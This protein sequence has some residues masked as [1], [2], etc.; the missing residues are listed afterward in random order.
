MKYL[1]LAFAVTLFISCAQ[2][3]KDNTQTKDQEEMMP[4]EPDGGIGDGAPSL[5]AAI[6]QTVESAHNK[7]AFLNNKMVSF[8]IVLSFGGSERLN[9]SIDM[10]TDTSQLRINKK[11]GS[12]QI[13]DGEH[14]YVTPADANTQGARFSAFTWTYF[15][16]LPYKLT[17]N[18]VNIEIKNK[19]PMS[20]DTMMNAFK[21]TFDAGIGDAPDDYYVVYTND[22]NQIKAAGYIVTYGGTSTQKAEENAHAIV[23]DD[24]QIVNG[25]PIA[26]SWKFYNWRAEKGIYDDP[27]GQA[28]ISNI[29]F[30]NGVGDTFTAPTNSV[31][32][33]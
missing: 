19:M 23:Y 21:M 9:G 1:L 26:T 11:D 28:T 6:V 8:D 29:T 17:D 15:F 7:Q 18:G 2:S 14:L 3:T 5:D 25:I 30:S 31:K 32:V 27:I 24:Y 10:L 16:A 4:V 33:K 20:N 13:F 12:A 22:N